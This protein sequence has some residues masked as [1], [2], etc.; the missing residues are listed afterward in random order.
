MEWD[1]RE[2]GMVCLSVITLGFAALSYFIPELRESADEV[3]MIAVGAIAALIKG[4]DN[5]TEQLLK[6]LVPPKVKR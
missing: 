6:L 5:K 4:R 1:D 2:T 3:A